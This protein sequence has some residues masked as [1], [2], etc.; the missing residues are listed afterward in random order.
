M[1]RS[2]GLPGTLGVL[3][4]VVNRYL[5]LDPETLD[6]LSEFSGRT[7]AVELVGLER[8]VLVHVTDQGVHLT[9]N[10]EQDSDAKVRAGP[11]TLW[12]AMILQQPG[13]SAFDPDLVIEGDAALVQGIRAVLERIDIDWEE[14]LSHYLGDSISHQLGNVSR[15]MARWGRQAGDTLMQDMAEYLT[16]EGRLTPHRE[17]LD[18]FVEAVD[19]LRE[20]ADRLEQRVRRLLDRWAET[21]S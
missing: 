19:G 7:V 10:Q 16:E 13:E 8:T 17:E 20:N 3:E 12:R 5:G 1:N 15:G 9:L 21:E 6:A 11:A 18:A 14:L 4:A 2:T